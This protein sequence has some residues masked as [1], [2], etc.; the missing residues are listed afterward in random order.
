[1]K[2]TLTLAAL[3]LVMSAAHSQV[4]VPTPTAGDRAILKRLRPGRPRL[5][6]LNSDLKRC[7]D[8]I[9][10]YPQAREWRDWRS[11]DRRRRDGDAMLDGEVHT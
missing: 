3:T 1:M 8:M 10:R 5:L 6:G 11:G 4:P 2:S 7:K 9:V